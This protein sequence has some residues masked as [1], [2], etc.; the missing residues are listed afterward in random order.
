MYAIVIS[1]VLAFIIAYSVTRRWRRQL[2]SVRKEDHAHVYIREGSMALTAQGDVF[3]HRHVQRVRRVE[4]D[5]G[6]SGGG[7]SFTS[8]SGRSATGHSGKY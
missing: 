4:K 3:L 5:S 6:G 7:S 8:S 1:L 2:I